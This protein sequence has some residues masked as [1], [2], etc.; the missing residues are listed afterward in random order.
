MDDGK[1]KMNLSLEKLVIPILRKNGFSGSIPHFRRIKEDS[2]DLITFQTD[3]NGGGFVIEL[4]KSKNG[5]FKTYF[6]KEI[7]PSKLTAHDLDKRI[8]IHPKGLLENSSTDDWFRYDGNNLDKEYD[9]ISE[10]VINQIPKMEELFAMKI[11]DWNIYI[12]RKYL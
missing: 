10:K 1:I 9:V 5:M 6:G 4:A 11:D 8:R 12:D 3:R 7:Y 2:I